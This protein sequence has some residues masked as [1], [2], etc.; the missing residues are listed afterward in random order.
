MRPF[1]LLVKPT[2]AD[3]NLACE[4]C[5]YLPKKNLYPETKQHR[6]SDSVLEHLIK[7]YM[8]TAQGSYSI[9]WQGGEPT[10]M[11][12]DFFSKAIEFQKKH[13]SARASLLPSF[14]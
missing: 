13:G 9:C 12:T 2:S 11:G 1:S 5:F 14:E 7:T 6:M 4:Y 3:C 8:E 10:L